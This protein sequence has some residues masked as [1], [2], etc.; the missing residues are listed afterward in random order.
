MP[1]HLKPSTDYAEDALLPGDP[2]RA[3]AL[4]QQLLTEPRMSNHAR[5]LWDI[6]DR[7]RRGIRSSMRMRS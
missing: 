5:G 3:L 4:A 2:G 1:H 6:R 7:L